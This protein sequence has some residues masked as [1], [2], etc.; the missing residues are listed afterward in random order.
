MTF[1]FESNDYAI[2]S[3]EIGSEHFGTIYST[4]FGMS[5]YEAQTA[6]IGGT[7]YRW[8]GGTRGELARDTGD[9]D[10]DFDTS[11][12]LFSL[13]QDNLMTIAGKGLSDIMAAAVEASADLSIFL[14]SVRYLDDPDTAAAEV[15]GFMTALLNGEY[16]ALPEK[17]VIEIGNETLDGSVERAEA[18]GTLADI[19]IRAITNVMERFEG[20]LPNIDIAVQ[21]GRSAEED[22]AIR[23]ELSDAALSAVDAL[24]AHH[25]PINMN[26]HNKTLEASSAIDAGDSRFTRS[27]DYIEAWEKA[28]SRAAK[29]ARIDLDF[30]VSAWTVGPSSSFSLSDLAYQDI[31]ARQARTTVDTFAQLLGA[32][33]DAASLWGIDARSNPNFFTKLEGGEVIVSHGGEAFKLMAESLQGMRLLDGYE[34]TDD[35]LSWV[36]GFED[37]QKYVLFVVANDIDGIET[38][39]IDVEGID[40]SQMIDVARVSTADLSG[41]GDLR[42]YETP[43]TSEYTFAVSGDTFDFDLT[44]DFEVNR[45]TIWKDDAAEPGQSANW[46]AHSAASALFSNGGAKSLLSQRDTD[47]SA[48]GTSADEII[49]DDAGNDLIAGGGGSD[50]FIFRPNGGDN[51]VFDFGEDGADEL[52]FY[53][54]GYRSDDEARA[55]MVAT[56]E[57]VYFEDQGT[58]IF[59]DGVIVDSVDAFEF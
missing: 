45:L 11:E 54:F 21:I 8:P 30:I 42:L 46:N 53:A 19:Q 29:D 50:Q 49:V 1:T 2:R 37:N 6:L 22:A 47:W 14:P 23:G 10:G 35:A 3:S 28:V 52:V 4:F 31:G 15:E 59:L 40:T 18:Y 26:N 27:I 38:V 48:K 13:T 5:A 58:S 56:D 7:S 55:Q 44:Q 9:K 43:E 25:L 41:S 36:Y 51:I 24:I 33:A 39:T 57:G 12:Y 20:D 34:Q 32:G 17:L 16:G